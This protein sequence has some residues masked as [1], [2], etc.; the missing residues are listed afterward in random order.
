LLGIIGSCRKFDYHGL[1]IKESCKVVS[2]G[3]IGTDNTE[4]TYTYDSKGFI[5]KEAHSYNGSHY[6]TI[7]YNRNKKGE[8]INDIWRYFSAGE[9]TGSFRDFYLYSGGRLSSII[10]Y[11]DE[12]VDTYDKT[13]KEPIAVI[14]SFKYNFMGLITEIKI[15][16]PDY[17]YLSTANA[18]EYYNSGLIKKSSFLYNVTEAYPGT[19]EVSSFQLFKPVGTPSLSPDT[20]LIEHGLPYFTAYDDAFAIGYMGVGSTIET[21][22]MR[23]DE[24]QFIKRR[25]VKS[26]E[27]DE[28]GYTKS[29]VYSNEDGSSEFGFVYGFDCG[30]K[31]KN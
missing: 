27:V 8:I 4:I 2:L 26:N 31:G 7:E 14:H 1:P 12:S 5:S 11:W 20:Y 16:L 17:P 28:R 29:I 30:R 24:P 18:F 15:E 23:N 22:S 3:M 13:G 25:I 21:Y 9:E 6:L 19:F 10:S